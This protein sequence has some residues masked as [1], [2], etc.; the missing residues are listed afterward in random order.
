MWDLALDMPP[1]PRSDTPVIAYRQ[2]PQR[3]PWECQPHND[4][5]IHYHADAVTTAHSSLEPREN[6][7]LSFQP[8]TEL[9]KRLWALRQAYVQSGG[10]LLSAEGLEEELRLR[11][12]GVNRA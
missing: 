9:G 1:F 7:Q 4:W 11:R 8:R 5:T 12:G 3:Q 2:E 10:Q 6:A